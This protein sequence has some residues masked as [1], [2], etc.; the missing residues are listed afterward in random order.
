MT[1]EQYFIQEKDQKFFFG[2]SE[3]LQVEIVHKTPT[4][5][6]KKTKDYPHVLP[7]WFPRDTHDLRITE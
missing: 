3:H 6:T 7:S 4:V 5:C 2:K 1:H